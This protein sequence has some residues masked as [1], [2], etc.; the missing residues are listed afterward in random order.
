V[1]VTWCGKQVVKIGNESFSL[2]EL[3]EK[4]LKISF[5]EGISQPT[6]LRKAPGLE[7]L[8]KIKKFSCQANKQL[9]K[10]DFFTLFTRAI[11]WIQDRTLGAISPQWHTNY[12]ETMRQSA[13]KNFRSFIVDE[14]GEIV[15]K[16]KASQ[17]LKKAYTELLMQAATDQKKS[18]KMMREL[19]DWCDGIESYETTYQTLGIALFYQIVHPDY[20]HFSDETLL[21]IMNQIPGCVEEI[22]SKSVLTKVAENLWDFNEDKEIFHKKLQKAIQRDG[23][24]LN[25]RLN[26]AKQCGSRGDLQ[27]L[28]KNAKYLMQTLHF[29]PSYFLFFES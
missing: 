7:I 20:D 22:C 3:T 29:V 10:K 4:V 8:R 13:K 21:F 23:S 6:A 28:R 12:I 14:S 19:K 2:Q 27:G 17:V 9:E 18:K 26:W 5:C 24:F 25:Q 15:Q 16:D 11:L 1:S